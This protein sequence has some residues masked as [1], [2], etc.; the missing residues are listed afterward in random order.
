MEYIYLKYLKLIR[1]KHWIKNL[2][3]FIPIVLSGNLTNLG[4]FGK[5]IVAFVCMSCSASI[6]Y[7]CNDIMDRQSDS[8]HP[9][10][11][12]RPLACG[13]V[14][15][16]VAWIL[17]ILFLLIGSCACILT[18]D[19]FRFAVTPI[20]YLFINILYSKA[21]KHIALLDIVVLVFGY[22]LRLFYGGWVIDV[23]ISTWVFLTMMTGAMFLAFGKRRGEKDRFGSSAR[24]SL[25][26]YT[27]LFLDHGVTISL[28]TTIVFYSMTCINTESS[29]AQSGIDML[30]S[31]PVVF[32]MLLRYLMLIDGD[33]SK[34]IDGD[35]VSVITSDKPLLLMGVVF[36]VF[37]ILSIYS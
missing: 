24:K 35:P 20:A 32:L 34:S 37:V 12:R 2:I 11:C 17:I 30:W 10:K 4:C 3:V 1:I 22:L 18:K 5:T 36:S 6:V 31:V 9:V 25:N 19:P 8:M 28:S 26:G 23:E 33:E 21:L 13:N 14:S 7:I 27:D 15:V 16:R 29:L